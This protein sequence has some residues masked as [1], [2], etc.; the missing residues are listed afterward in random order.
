MTTRVGFARVNR[1]IRGSRRVVPVKWVEMTACRAGSIEWWRG[2]RRCRRVLLVEPDRE[3]SFHLRPA[4]VE[5]E[6]VSNML[7]MRRGSEQAY[8]RLLVGAVSEKGSDGF[9]VTCVQDEGV[10]SRSV[11]NSG[12]RKHTSI[13]S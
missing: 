5:K 1:S 11:K 4:G 2:E 7:K 10:I 8:P 9:E 6:R 13:S 3:E 12:S